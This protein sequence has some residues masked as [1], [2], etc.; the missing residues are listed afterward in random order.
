[1]NSTYSNFHNYLNDNI[2]STKLSVI[3]L[4]ENLYDMRQSAI[5]VKVNWLRS[6]QEIT[7][8]EILR[9]INFKETKPSHCLPILLI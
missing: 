6:T 4:I 7:G 8:Y 5:K 9:K 3:F 2:L 1:M